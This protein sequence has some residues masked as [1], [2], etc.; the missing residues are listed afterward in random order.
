MNVIDQT[1]FN[2][3][4]FGGQ[5]KKLDAKMSRNFRASQI[6]SKNIVALFGLVIHIS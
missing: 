3:T 6:S 1:A 2:G 4:H 5:K